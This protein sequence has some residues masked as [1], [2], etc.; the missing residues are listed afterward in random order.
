ML[1][2]SE[3][4]EIGKVPPK[5]MEGLIKKTQSLPEEFW[6]FDTSRKEKYTM[7]YATHSLS[8]T[9]Q[10]DHPIYNS[11]KA[12]YR[13]D[14]DEIAKIAGQHYG[15]IGEVFRSIIVKLDPWSQID[16]H[17]DSLDYATKHFAGTTRIHVPIITHPDC[18]FIVGET[19]KNMEVGSIY[20]IDNYTKLH[21]VENNSP[22]A[23]VHIVI[24][25]FLK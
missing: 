25:I 11:A 3:I 1:R 12:L 8:L 22:V 23:R 16:P 2:Q 7:H 19:S 24:D 21:W 14:L 6:D 18:M 4:R 9:P 10:K 15:M 5:T 17:V 20:Y 13:K